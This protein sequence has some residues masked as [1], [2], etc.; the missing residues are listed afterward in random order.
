MNMGFGITLL[1]GSL[2]FLLI[3]LLVLRL[4]DCTM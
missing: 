2:T 3:E 4:G 1:S